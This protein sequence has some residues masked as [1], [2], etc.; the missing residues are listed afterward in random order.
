M[1]QLIVEMLEILQEDMTYG[2][3]MEYCMVSVFTSTNLMDDILCT[4]MFRILEHIRI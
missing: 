4:K 2:E 3:Y 1:A